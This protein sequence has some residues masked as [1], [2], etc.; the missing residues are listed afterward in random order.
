MS[1]KQIKALSDG[2]EPKYRKL[3]LQIGKAAEAAYLKGGKNAMTKAIN[4]SRLPL[5]DLLAKNYA[6]ST[7]FGVSSMQ[8][9]RATKAR[10]P[11]NKT[12]VDPRADPDFAARIAAAY[13]KE[14]AN[15]KVDDIT[16]TT[17]DLARQAVAAGI[18]AEKTP[19]QIALL[20]RATVGEDVG[21]YRAKMI[22][23]TETAGAYN[24]ATHDTAEEMQASTGPL[25]KVWVAA[26]DDRVRETHADVDGTS[27][28]MDE[29]FSVG[30]SKMSY[31]SD[32]SGDAS[33][34]INCRCTLVYEPAE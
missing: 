28:P 5:R 27:I 13:V 26:S 9:R 34:V 30:D 25:N 14:H 11:A 2:I 32:P 18:E 6:S 19:G 15:D 21:S 3:F 8:L 4:D 20:I 1:E 22:A 29:D 24:S 17:L 12:F 10:R 7:A 31:P 33:E 23:R 16:N